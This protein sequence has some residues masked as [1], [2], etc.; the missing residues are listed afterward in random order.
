[1]TI[2]KKLG[3]TLGILAVIALVGFLVLREPMRNRAQTE[4]IL[5]EM[6]QRMAGLRAVDQ[7]ENG[8]NDLLQL[9]SE[10]EE[11]EAL[12]PYLP[13]LS[14]TE[15]NSLILQHDQE[16]AQAQSRFAEI[17]SEVEAALEKPYVA[18]QP[19]ENLDSLNVEFPPLRDLTLSLASHGVYEFK[20]GD[21]RAGLK[22]ILLAASW[23]AK[24]P[25]ETGI[26]GIGIQASLMAKPLSLLSQIIEEEALSNDELKLIIGR[27]EGVELSDRDFA[28][29][30]DAEM[31]I[32]HNTLTDLA[33]G[34]ALT[35][36][37]LQSTMFS[38]GSPFSKPNRLTAPYFLRNRN[39]LVNFI[40]A[41]RADWAAHSVRGDLLS[42]ELDSRYLAHVPRILVP[43]Y[44]RAMLH[45][46]NLLTKVDASRAAAEIALYEKEHNSLPPSLAEANVSPQDYL[47]GKQLEYSH[48]GRTFTLKS[49]GPVYDEM[50]VENPFQYYPLR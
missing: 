20:T 9:C 14:L 1:M 7:R 16:F 19:A 25:S 40:T 30:L 50:G 39:I 24:I 26:M 38:S 22:L 35:N 49:R 29:A 18:W 5:S 10:K 48:K 32:M 34:K 41:H 12:F 23:P 36:P 11:S 2:G 15:I 21:R 45:H 8:Y 17:S 13:E 33:R 3:V 47:T 4:Q 31:V 27:L 44:L 28:E 46:G 43:N 37:Q 6:K 42:S